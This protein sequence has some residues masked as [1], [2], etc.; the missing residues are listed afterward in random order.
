METQ[1]SKCHQ[2]E[3]QYRPK[4]QKLQC[5]DILDKINNISNQIRSNFD[6][7]DMEDETKNL[8]SSLLGL[9]GQNVSEMVSHS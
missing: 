9:F 4:L 6:Q 7:R 5:D 1:K 3:V 2:L 8:Y